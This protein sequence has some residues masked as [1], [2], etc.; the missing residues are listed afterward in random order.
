MSFVQHGVAARRFESSSTGDSCRTKVMQLC[1][2]F[3]SQHQKLCGIPTTA[4]RTVPLVLRPFMW[5]QEI[6]R[7]GY[8]SN[9]SRPD[10]PDRPFTARPFTLRHAKFLPQLALGAT[11]HS[12]RFG[13]LKRQDELPTQRQRLLDRSR[14]LGTCIACCNATITLRRGAQCQRRSRSID[15]E[16]VVY[17][18]TQAARK[19]DS[20]S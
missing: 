10:A 1:V 13:L 4:P 15:D 16:Y 20:V 14:W 17:R 11:T 9:Y 5:L 12:S 18:S 7:C 6:L 8:R 19:R 3:V 2:T